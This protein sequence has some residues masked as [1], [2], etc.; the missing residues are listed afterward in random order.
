MDRAASDRAASRDEES[1]CWPAWLVLLRSVGDPERLAAW[2]GRHADGCPACR[3]VV[4]RVDRDRA[5]RPDDLPLVAEA[6]PR[7]RAG[8]PMQVIR[9][10][11][12]EA[13]PPALPYAASVTNPLSSPSA[14]LPIV[15]YHRIEELEDTPLDSLWCVTWDTRLYFILIGPP[16]ALD[17]CAHGAVIR[18][19]DGE[20]L[21]QLVPA[22]ASTCRL[23]APEAAFDG[24][25]VLC[26]QSRLST[27]DLDA[28]DVEVPDLLATGIRLEPAPPDSSSL[29]RLVGDL[30]ARNR[31]TAFLDALPQ[32]PPAPAEAL[33]LGFY[34]RVL[35]LQGRLGPSDQKRLVELEWLPGDLRE[36]FAE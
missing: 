23:L 28:Q 25:A 16:A 1:E 29:R 20:T 35:H 26:L 3:A 12:D 4:A 9:H 17:S 6:A 2:R 13:C 32:E 8:Q 15:E 34:L 31:I 10:V 11:V 30:V 21:E 27:A 22:D 33:T 18:G 7:R 24:P 14:E 36:A 19:R 5:R